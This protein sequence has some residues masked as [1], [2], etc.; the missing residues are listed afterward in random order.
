MHWPTRLTTAF[1]SASRLKANNSRLTPGRPSGVSSGESSR[2]IAGFGVAAD[3]RRGVARGD[4]PGR[5]APR[6][7]VSAVTMSRAA[8]I[9]NASAKVST[10]VVPLISKLLPSPY[11]DS[12]SVT[13][14]KVMKISVGPAGPR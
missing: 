8:V 14:P 4:L 9:G 11:C 1:C 13:L 3:D 6:P 12:L 2:S 5:S 10:I 7:R